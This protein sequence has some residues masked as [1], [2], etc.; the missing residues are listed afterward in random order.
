MRRR[1]QRKISILLIIALVAMN[2]IGIRVPISVSATETGMTLL[3]DEDVL[4]LTKADK[5]NRTSVH[6]PS[7]VTNT[8]GTYYIFGSHMG[9]SKTNDLMNWDTVTNESLIVVFLEIQ[10]EKL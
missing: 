4:G 6:D 8:D 7:I 9:V 5:K 1:Y 3:T 2:L 10:M